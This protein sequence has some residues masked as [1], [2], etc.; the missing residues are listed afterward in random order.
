MDW[1]IKVSDRNQPVKEATGEEVIFTSARNNLKVPE[2][3]TTTISVTSGVGSATIPHQKVFRPV[4]FVFVAFATGNFYLP[5]YVTGGLTSYY[6]D[7]TNLVITLNS[8]SSSDGTTFTIYY[9]ISDT[10][11][12]E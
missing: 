6:V 8:P 4:A 7:S 11:S 3:L 5:T 9:N 1:G 10:E 12:A 2:W